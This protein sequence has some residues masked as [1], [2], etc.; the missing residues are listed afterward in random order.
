M[1]SLCRVA[2]R[3]RAVLITGSA[4]TAHIGTYRT[5]LERIAIA[6]A[7]ARWAAG[8]RAALRRA[9]VNSLAVPGARNPVMLQVGSQFNARH[10]EALADKSERLAYFVDYLWRDAR[11]ADRAPVLDDGALFDA[12][13]PDAL[14]SPVGR[15][16]HLDH[17]PRD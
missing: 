11:A 17:S 12:V 3:R 10:F 5:V 13:D 2:S 8:A 7:V 6:S 4:T 9:A 16:L 14:D 1:T 15:A